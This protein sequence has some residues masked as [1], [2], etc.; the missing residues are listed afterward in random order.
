MHPIIVCA[1]TAFLSSPASILTCVV[2]RTNVY[3]MVLIYSYRCL[4]LLTYTSYLFMVAYIQG[5][6]SEW[7]KNGL[8]SC[9]RYTYKCMLIA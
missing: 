2:L 1:E 3:P 4:L 9:I 8:V 7:Y 5:F 6:F